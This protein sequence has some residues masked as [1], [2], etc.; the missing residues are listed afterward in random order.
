ML[1]TYF[2]ISWC[3]LLL[4]E[5]ITRLA[6]PMGPVVEPSQSHSM[7]GDKHACDSCDNWH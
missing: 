7:A 3:V 4:F 6:G 5:S 2:L 1:T